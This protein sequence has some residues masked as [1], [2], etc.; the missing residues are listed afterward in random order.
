MMTKENG[1]I[2]SCTRGSNLATLRFTNSQAIY[3]KV[4]LSRNYTN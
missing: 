1:K 4:A 3:L 2:L